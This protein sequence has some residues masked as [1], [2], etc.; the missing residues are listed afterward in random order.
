MGE[1]FQLMARKQDVRSRIERLRRQ[2]EHERSLGERANLR[3][4]RT[5]ENQLERLM[6]E[7]YNLRVAIDQSR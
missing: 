3:R 2:L 7:E 1:R 5:L 6:A 4:L